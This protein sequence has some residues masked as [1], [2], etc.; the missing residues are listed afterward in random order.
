MTP[1]ELQDRLARTLEDR[2]LSRGERQ[3]LRRILAELSPNADHRALR[4]FAFELARAA[5]VDTANGHVLD[6]LEDVVKVLEGG[7]PSETSSPLSEAYFS[8]GD[9]CPRAIIGLLENAKRTADV[10]VFTIT[11]DRLSAALLDAH[12]RG[13]SFRVITDNDKAFDEGSD[14]DRISR[15]GVPVRV[16]RTRFHMHHKFAVID[17]QWLISGSYNWTRGASVTTRRT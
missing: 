8:P 7:E 15:A 13:I 16:D 11:D 3:D 6:W 4:Q 17:G 14:V 1:Q 2:R 5:P 9:D 10:C 12:H